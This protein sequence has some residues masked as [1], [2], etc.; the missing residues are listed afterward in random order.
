MVLREGGSAKQVENNQPHSVTIST[1]LG[2]DFAG[3]GIK[4]HTLSGDKV[5]PKR[6]TNFL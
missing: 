2:N 6:G 5:S 3:G 1:W 4:S